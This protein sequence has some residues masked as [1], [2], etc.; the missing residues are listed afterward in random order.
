MY[1]SVC[2]R[3]HDT[4]SPPPGEGLSASVSWSL[5]WALAQLCLLKGTLDAGGFSDVGAN[6]PTTGLIQVSES[7]YF[8]HL[9]FGINRKGTDFPAKGSV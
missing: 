2:A 4:W 6:N 9:S 3:P 7:G 5:P 8:L 1:A